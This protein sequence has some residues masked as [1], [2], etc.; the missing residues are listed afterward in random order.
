MTGEQIIFLILSVLMIGS[1]LLMIHSRH[2]VYSAVFMIV[3][4]FGIAGCFVLLD[5][6]FLA[7]LQVLV[8]AGAI[9]VLFLF[10]VMLLNVDQEASYLPSLTVPGIGLV[11]GFLGFS[12]AML[13][14][15]VQQG[16]SVLP[17]ASEVSWVLTSGE[18]G[19]SILSVGNLATRLFYDH[20][21]PFEAISMLLLSAVLGVVVL[22]K[23]RLN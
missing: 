9:M 1:S 23:R 12:G 5:S 10:I 16:T 14:S 4:M 7:V 8:Y 22:S 21:F 13:W 2:P 18:S 11:A 15:M 3:S 6:F 19:K 20:W 17:A